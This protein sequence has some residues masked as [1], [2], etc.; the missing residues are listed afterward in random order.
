[1]SGPPGPLT[2][3]GRPLFQGLLDAKAMAERAENGDS[4]LV[5]FGIVEQQPDGSRAEIGI[6]HLR[7]HGWDW[8]L[9]A[10]ADITEGHVENGRVQFELRK[11]VK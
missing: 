11:R 10:G 9:T 3:G 4:E 1:M 5:I 7:P 6:A 2:L 8:M